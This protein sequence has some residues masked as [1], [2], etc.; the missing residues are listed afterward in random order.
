MTADPRVVA[1]AATIPTASYEEV[2]QLAVQGA[3]VIHPRAVEIALRHNLPL[4]IKSTF[5][6][7]AGTLVTN[8]RNGT[9]ERLRA[10][11]AVGLAHKNGYGIIRLAW[12]EA[13]SGSA[14]LERL[15]ASG[16]EADLINITPQ[17]IEIIAS[18]ADLEVA[19]ALAG[20]AGLDI[21]E[22]IADCAKITLVGCAASSAAVVNTFVDLL[23]RAGIGVL[24][25]Y[26]SPFAVSGIVAGEEAAA[27]LEVLHAGILGHQGKGG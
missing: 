12:G 10:R 20:D 6:P 18:Q 15:A 9:I 14:V 1:G 21:R 7:G 25:T 3:K 27:A 16:L 4:R 5:A 2:F 26:T 23:C 11:A 24:Q 13:G 19:A 22:Q 17:G 8:D